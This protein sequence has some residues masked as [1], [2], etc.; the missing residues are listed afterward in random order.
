MTW[1]EVRRGRQNNKPPAPL[2]GSPAV[3]GSF[4]ASKDYV[5]EEA[6]TRSFAA[7]AL[8]GCAFVDQEM[9]YR[10]SGH[11]TAETPVCVLAL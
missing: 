8:A 3:L 4:V 6:R 10:D 2:M 7:P 9:M 1:R 11:R 5:A